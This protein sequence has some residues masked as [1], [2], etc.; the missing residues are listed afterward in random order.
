MSI[1]AFSLILLV[2][3]WLAIAIG[4]PAGGLACF[5]ACMVLQGLDWLEGHRG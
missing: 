4:N 2:F 1:H 3:G 5:V